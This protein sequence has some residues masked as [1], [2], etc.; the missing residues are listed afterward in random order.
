MKKI[1]LLLTL[2]MT[3]F[4]AACLQEEPPVDP[5]VNTDQ[6]LSSVESVDA[7]RT[8]VEPSK[9]ASP[10]AVLPCCVQAMLPVCA[11]TYKRPPQL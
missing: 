3:L 9:S 4:L 7:L 10:R 2:L 6:G 11:C 1:T 5:V 8:L